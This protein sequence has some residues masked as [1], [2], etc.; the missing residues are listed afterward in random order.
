[1]SN[2]WDG[3]DDNNGELYVSQYADLESAPGGSG[4]YFDPGLP[5]AYAAFNGAAVTARW[6]ATAN[7]LVSVDAYFTNES[8]NSKPVSVLVM[9]GTTSIFS[10]TLTGF[11]GYWPNRTLRQPNFSTSYDGTLFVPA[12]SYVEFSVLANQAAQGAPMGG[13]DADVTPNPVV[14]TNVS[15]VHDI[16]ALSA[17]TPVVTNTPLVVTAG[18]GTFSDGSCC[19]EQQDR[20]AGIKVM[21]A[22][23]IVLNDGDRVTFYG[24]TALDANN[25]TYVAIYALSSQTAGTPLESLGTGGKTIAATTGIDHDGLLVRVWGTV[26]SRSTGS[27]TINDGNGTA[28]EVLV[29]N[30]SG[31]IGIPVLTAHMGITGVV[32]ETTG[33]ALV[34]CPRAVADV[35]TYSAK[36]F[37]NAATEFGDTNPSGAWTYGYYNAGTFTLDPAF[38]T[39]GE[40]L[41]WRDILAECRRSGQSVRQP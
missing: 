35:T 20:S 4:V 5:T 3:S 23:G 17:G 18:T 27:F 21:P 19:V 28:V 15:T 9:Q 29:S 12:G 38:V 40:I 34:I 25:D 16:R 11:N 26:A 7:S 2:V 6:T 31:V 8:P 41:G 33:G 32:E 22:S 10:N 39:D 13:I 30:T 1:M 24:T 36:T 37:W 14:W